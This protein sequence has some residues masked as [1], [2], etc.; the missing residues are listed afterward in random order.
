[1]ETLKEYEFKVVRADDQS[2]VMKV[3]YRAG[4]TGVPS[5]HELEVNLV[6]LGYKV[7]YVEGIYET[8]KPLAILTE[9][10]EP[11]KYDVPA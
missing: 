6:K 2:K 8:R 11:S 4:D 5:R 1:M 10:Y 3:R 9:A 7:L